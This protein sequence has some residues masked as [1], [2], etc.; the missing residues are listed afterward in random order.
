M[1]EKRESLRDL[2]VLALESRRAAEMAELIR[3]HGGTPLVA[4]A[5]REIPIEENREAT[6]FVDDLEGGRVDAVIF[7]TGVG[8]RTLVEAV[9]SRCPRAHLIDLL[10]RCRLIARGPKP[11]AALRELGLQ[12][13]LVAPEPNTWREILAGLDRALPVAGLRLAV[14][15]YGQSNPELLAGLRDRG[16]EVSVV[17]V[18]RWALPDDTAPLRR[19]VA[20]LRAARVHIALFTSATQ[21][22]HL[23]LVARQEGINHEELRAAFATVVVASIGPV[24]TEAIARHGLP[25]DLE[26]E[27]PKMGRLM[28]AVARRGPALL[29]AKRA[30]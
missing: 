14:Q 16:A 12:P 15:E 25:V 11:V 7:L 22:E 4:P 8:T 5:M 18:Y 10:K 21:V 9:E 20:E 29:R 26:P 2:R 6:A 13:A 1:G 23:F 24:C 30:S 3:R 19:A 17:P 28:S 27:H